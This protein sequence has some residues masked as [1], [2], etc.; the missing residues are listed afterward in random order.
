M[1][2]AGHRRHIYVERIQIELSPPQSTFTQ[3]TLKTGIRS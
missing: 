1:Q 3:Q 2:L